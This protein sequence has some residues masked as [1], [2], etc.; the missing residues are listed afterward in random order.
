MP[1][2]EPNVDSGHQLNSGVSMNHRLDAVNPAAPWLSAQ[3]L[4]DPVM[5]AKA[6]VSP[7]PSANLVR[8]PWHA[9]GMKQRCR[10]V[11][12]RR[13]PAREAKAR[14]TGSGRP[15]WNVSF[16]F[17]PPD[18]AV[19]ISVLMGS[20]SG[21]LSSTVFVAAARAM[22]T[23]SVH[24]KARVPGDRWPA[25][26]VVFDRIEG[27][28][29]RLGDH[30]LTG[31]QIDMVVPESEGM[32]RLRRMNYADPPLTRRLD[33]SARRS[34]DAVLPRDLRT[35]SALVLRQE[36]ARSFRPNA[37]E[38]MTFSPRVASVPR[39]LNPEVKRDATALTGQTA[40]GDVR[41]WRMIPVVPVIRFQRDEVAAFFSMLPRMALLFWPNCGHSVRADVS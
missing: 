5:K 14:E 19:L 23:V 26:V 1:P 9:I 12:G 27:T 30:R 33:V 11:N 2:E 34:R 36:N 10:V 8:P 20:A 13:C 18:S 21:L 35:L 32:V 4:A 3:A 15:E 28:D 17:R 7:V 25:I 40:T 31:R 39:S 29:P 24:R 41:Q 38:E 16:Q 37:V 22:G 6:A